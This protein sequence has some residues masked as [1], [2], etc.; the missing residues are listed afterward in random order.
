[1]THESIKTAFSNAVS[2]VASGISLYAIHP[3]R[4]LL[5]TIIK[6][7]SF[8]NCQNGSKTIICMYVPPRYAGINM[9]W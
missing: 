4:D 9:R 7:R 6:F 2:Q 3:G 1:M 8:N 5:L